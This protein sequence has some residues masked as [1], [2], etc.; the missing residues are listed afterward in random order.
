M[1]VLKKKFRKTKPITPKPL[2][3][4]KIKPKVGKWCDCYEGRLP[5]PMEC[6]NN[7]ISPV[8][9][10]FKEGKKTML[11]DRSMCIDCA[12]QV[13]WQSWKNREWDKIKIA[14]AKGEDLRDMNPPM[15]ILK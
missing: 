15:G 5:F 6:Q 10:M 13:E 2:L 11:Y 12:R 4:I 1:K 7:K 14:I 3:R 9:C 8:S